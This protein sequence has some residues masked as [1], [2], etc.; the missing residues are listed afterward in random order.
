MGKVV[1]VK[2]T[3][4]EQGYTQGK[5]LASEINGNIR[6][7]NEY[8]K[9]TGCGGERYKDFVKRSVKY[10]EKSHP[11]IIEEMRGIAEGSGIPYDDIVTINIPA[12]YMTAYLAEECSMLMVR[13]KATADGSTYLIKNRDS[14]M[15]THHAVI[16]REYDNGDVSI[17]LNGSGIVTYPGNGINNYGL[18]VATTGFWSNKTTVVMDDIDSCSIIINIH[19]LLRD[20]KTV[21]DVVD[22]IKAYNRMNGINIIAV[23]DKSAAAIEVTRDNVYVQWDKGDG[24]LMRSNHYISNDFKYLNPDEDATKSI[25]A[26]ESTFKRYERMSEIVKQKYG[27]LRFQ[28]IYRIM[29]D[30]QNG[31]VN[32]I[33]R[34]MEDTKRAATIATCLVALEDREVWTSFGNP[35]EAL[36]FAAIK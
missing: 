25:F 32:T 29:S 31:P 34:H 13:G 36:N 23:D 33:C 15:D 4:Y 19:F 17:E 1:R 16:Q 8:I 26:Y 10:T 11:E 2:G 12:Y 20:C 35:C 28:D 7:I 3:P 27:K 9:K 21:Q 30:H 6:Y 18:A 5:A 22:Y 24:V 14:F